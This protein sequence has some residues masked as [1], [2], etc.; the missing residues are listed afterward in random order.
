MFSYP[1][2]EIYEVLVETD[3][4]FDQSVEVLKLKLKKDVQEFSL[5]DEDLENYLISDPYET[6]MEI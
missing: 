5:G 3:F 4:N 6:G 1:K 2:E